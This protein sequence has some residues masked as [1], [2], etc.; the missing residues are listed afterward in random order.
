MKF[1]N[2]ILDIEDKIKEVLNPNVIDEKGGL[3]RT[4]DP[5]FFG[6]GTDLGNPLPEDKIDFR[7][8]KNSDSDSYGYMLGNWNSDTKAN[9]ILPA[10]LFNSSINIDKE[11]VETLQ[12]TYYARILD[13]DDKFIKTEWCIDEELEHYQVR[14]IPREIVDNSLLNQSQKLVIR[15]YVQT[16]SMR[17]NFID[18][19][20]IVEDSIF[21]FDSELEDIAIKLFKKEID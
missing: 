9:E 11:S 21:E 14:L 20:Y 17:Y 4:F 16:G 12:A 13:W 3:R 6:G 18:G 2:D 19:N 5:V 1:E 8:T 7:K 15:L 10:N